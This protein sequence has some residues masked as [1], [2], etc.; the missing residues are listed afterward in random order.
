MPLTYARFYL[1]Q[2]QKIDQ[3]LDRK[4]NE[5]QASYKTQVI[6]A[7]ICIDEQLIMLENMFPP[8]FLNKANFLRLVTFDK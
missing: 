1:Q 6:P 7:I 2:S 8:I 5:T 3:T 4:K